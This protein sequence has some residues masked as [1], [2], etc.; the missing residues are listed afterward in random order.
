MRMSFLADVLDGLS[1]TPRSIPCKYFYDRTGSELFDRI[2]EQPEYYLTRAETAL[3][4]AHAASIAE[5]LG[6]HIDLV[7][8]GSGSSVKTRILLDALRAPARYVPV[9]IS[10]EHLRASARRL[11]RAYPDLAIEPLAADYA[12]PIEGLR[13]VR[14]ARRVVFFPGSS[15]GNFEPLEAVRFLAR[16][17]ALAGPRGIVLIGVDLPKEASILERAYDDAAGATRAFNLHVLHRMQRELGAEVEVRQFRH[18]AP[19]QVERSRIEMRLVATRATEVRVGG[20]SFSLGK[21]EHIVTEHCYKHDVASF[22]SLARK[23]GLAA[24]P[25][26]LDPDGLVSMHW[27]EVDRLEIEEL[28]IDQGQVRA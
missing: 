4:R 25:V 11:A 22:R 26:W 9:D 2:T 14:G 1:A 27:L 19:W 21:D 24:G 20:T 16:A 3:L 28:Q 12:R 6:P 18:A 17:A 15:I 23:A 10:G 13:T 8:L 7:E 5:A